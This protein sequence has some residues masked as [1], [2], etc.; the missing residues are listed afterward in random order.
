MPPFPVK[1]QKGRS[2]PKI[3]VKGV[4]PTHEPDEDEEM[5]AE[6]GDEAKDDSEE[7]GPRARPQRH[8]LPNPD[9]EN[10]DDDDDDGDGEEDGATKKKIKSKEERKQEKMAM[11]GKRSE[12]MEEKNGRTV[13]VGNLPST[14]QPRVSAATS[15]YRSFPVSSH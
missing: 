10:S 8:R 14:C 6:E 13:F 2:G 11:K 9:D 3:H 15:V 1:R 4:I 7:E 12:R 5:V